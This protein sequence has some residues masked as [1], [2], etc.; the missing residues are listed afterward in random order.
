MGFATFATWPLWLSLLIVAVFT[1]GAMAVSHQ[2]RRRID[3]ER[4]M[5]NNEVA[6]FKFA[7]MGVIYAVMLGFAVIVVWE[8]YHD[9][10]VAVAQEASAIVALYRLAGGFG[11]DG[12]VAARAHIEDYLSSVITDDWP[13]MARGGLSPKATDSL[14]ELYAEVLSRTGSGEHSA[15]LSE[16]FYQLDQ[17]TSARRQRLVLCGGIVPGVIWI[18]LFTGA[19]LT[20]GFTMFFGTRNPRAEMLMTGILALMIFT[21]LMVIG[22]IDYPFT[23]DISVRPDPLT[24]ALRE[25]SVADA[26][27]REE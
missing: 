15:L 19:A 5:S 11:P 23:G 13:A 20:I 10:E 17:I 22:T 8:K 27:R 25:F 26:A 16:M 6:G 18:A 24:E 9:A 3:L 2:I 1:A 7:T 12:R 4:L 14:N 21:V